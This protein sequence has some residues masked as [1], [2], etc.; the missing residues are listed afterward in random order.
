MV[1]WDV[2][3]RCGQIRGS[4]L[5]HSVQNEAFIKMLRLLESNGS[6]LDCSLGH[7][8]THGRLHI[9]VSVQLLHNRRVFSLTLLIAKSQVCL[10][11]QLHLLLIEKLLLLLLMMM[12]LLVHRDCAKAA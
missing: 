6:I 1:R 9:R 5:H 8:H 2:T 12:L 7:C 4:S 3:H 10:L 11:I